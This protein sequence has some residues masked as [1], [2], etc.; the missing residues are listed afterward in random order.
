LLLLFIPGSRKLLK[1]FARVPLE[2]RPAAMLAHAVQSGKEWVLSQRSA[3]RDEHDF[4]S[5]E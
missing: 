1:A 3:A 4:A 5:S 2:A